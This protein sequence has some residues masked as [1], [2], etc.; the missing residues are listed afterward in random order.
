M[1]F[2]IFKCST[3]QSLHGVTA[4][5]TGAK[6]PRNACPGGRWVP[7]VSLDQSAIGFNAVEAQ[8]GISAQGFHLFRV[9]IEMN[10]P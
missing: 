8:Q 10:G 6:L 4:D 2:Y 7:R 9:K 3:D 1:T 5:P